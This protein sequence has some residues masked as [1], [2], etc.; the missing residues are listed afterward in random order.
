MFGTCNAMFI[1]FIFSA[2]QLQAMVR[3]PTLL[4]LDWQKQC[5]EVMNTT[6][7]I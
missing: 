6:H 1:G 7:V 4:L 5:E 3:I 2:D